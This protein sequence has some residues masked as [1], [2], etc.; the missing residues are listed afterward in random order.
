MQLGG[1]G[2]SLAKGR[3]VEGQPS[4]GVVLE[5]SGRKGAV[6]DAKPK[7]PLPAERADTITITFLT[8][9]LLLTLPAWPARPAG[10]HR[11]LGHLH[12]PRQETFQAQGLTAC[13]WL[14]GARP[15]GEQSKRPKHRALQPP[16]AACRPPGPAVGGESEPGAE[17]SG[18]GAASR[19]EAPHEETP[20]GAWRNGRLQ[21]ENHR[22]V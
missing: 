8:L 19:P 10:C 15:S 22:I 2:G 16:P 11:P 21:S 17:S 3:S 4:T 12:L 14:P 20:R 13:S 5:Q 6:E 18:A 1:T 9:L 7:A